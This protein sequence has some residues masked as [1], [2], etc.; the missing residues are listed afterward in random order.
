MLPELGVI[1]DA[2]TG[3]F[4]ARDLIQTDTL[5][6]FLTHIHLDHCIGLTF[7]YDVLYQK[8]M[9]RVTVHLAE[10]K[11]EAIEKHLFSESLF[12]VKPNFDFQPLSN[13]PVALN[14][15]SQILAIPLDHPGGAHGFRIDWPDRSCAYITDTTASPDANYVGAVANAN[16]LIHEC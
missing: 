2:G 13:R 8:E 5:D 16:T 11:I 15:G 7:L 6:I 3:I 9:Q 14:D 12:P 10:D 1:F 4:R